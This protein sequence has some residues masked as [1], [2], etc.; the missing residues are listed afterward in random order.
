[1]NDKEDTDGVK[2]GRS[3]REMGDEIESTSK[4]ASPKIDFENIRRPQYFDELPEDCF[5]ESRKETF[6]TI[7]CCW[8]NEKELKNAL[9]NSKD[10]VETFSLKCDGVSKSFNFCRPMFAITSEQW[11]NSTKNVDSIP[12]M[13]SFLENMMCL[14]FGPSESFQKPAVP[15]VRAV[16]A[17][18]VIDD[19]WTVCSIDLPCYFYLDVLK[20]LLKDLMD[21]FYLL[22]NSPTF[23]SLSDVTKDI[24]FRRNLIK[25]QSIFPKC[26][27][28]WRAKEQMERRFDLPCVERHLPT[29][30]ST[31]TTKYSIEKAAR[32]NGLFFDPSDGRLCKTNY[33]WPPP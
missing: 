13:V 21:F 1:M 8:I 16:Y 18:K 32:T 9:V 5:I 25:D 7:G 24:F 12:K 19:P 26:I 17:I 20:N 30:F 33:P 27:S 11:D 22:Y 28:E 2:E 23:G 3:L 15:F 6:I 10:L 29:L 4:K 31:L 14:I